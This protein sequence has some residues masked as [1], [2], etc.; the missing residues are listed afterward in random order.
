MAE[1]K[2]FWGIE[3]AANEG[4]FSGSRNS[5]AK[6]VADIFKVCGLFGWTVSEAKMTKRMNRVTFITEAAGQ[7]SKQPTHDGCVPWGNCVQAR[8]SYR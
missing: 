2:P 3:Y 5:L 7:L 1:P 6:I 4:I 8:R